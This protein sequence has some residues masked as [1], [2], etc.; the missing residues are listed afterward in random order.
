MPVEQLKR[1][2]KIEENYIYAVDRIKDVIISGGKN[3]SLREDEE[4][5]Y[6]HPGVLEAEQARRVNRIYGGD[7]DRE[8]QFGT[9]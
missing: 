8:L 5:I 7:A 1:A 3:I 9:Y 2:I 4:A 6:A